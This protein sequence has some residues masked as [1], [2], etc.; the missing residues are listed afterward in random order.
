MNVGCDGLEPYSVFTRKQLDRSQAP[1][2][3]HHLRSHLPSASFGNPQNLLDS[4][5]GT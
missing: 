1:S 2:P 5:S 4:A 3:G